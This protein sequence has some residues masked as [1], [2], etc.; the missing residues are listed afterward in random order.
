MNKSKKNEL[1][2]SK[3][4]KK[5]EAYN[6]SLYL[7]KFLITDLTNKFDKIKSKKKSSKNMD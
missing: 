1:L 5:S 2:S 3:N 7:V 4:A 6:K